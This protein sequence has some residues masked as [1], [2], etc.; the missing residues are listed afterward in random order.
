MENEFEFYKPTSIL[1]YVYER[2]TMSLGQFMKKKLLNVAEV[3]L[4]I[5]TESDIEQWGEYGYLD[6]NYDY[7]CKQQ[8]YLSPV[9]N[10]ILMNMQDNKLPKSFLLIWYKGK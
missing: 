1:D 3:L 9:L 5:T 7:L 8:K 4:L 6:L 2:P 10:Q